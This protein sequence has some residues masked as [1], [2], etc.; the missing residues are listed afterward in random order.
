M[1]HL[2]PAASAAS[3]P[4]TACAHV[5]AVTFLSASHCKA[6]GNQPQLS[7]T[8]YSMIS[9]TDA[10]PCREPLMKPIFVRI[11]HPEGYEDVCDELVFEG[12]IREAMQQGWTCS[13]MDPERGSINPGTETW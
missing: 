11:D 8:N 5:A 6:I 7:F 4:A 3:G 1:I 12:A 2:L 9:S 10:D 13:L